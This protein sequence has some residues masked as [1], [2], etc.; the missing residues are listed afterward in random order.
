MN[1]DTLFERQ[2]MYC[3]KQKEAEWEEKHT[4]SFSYIQECQQVPFHSSI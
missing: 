4:K 2:E 3:R 1:V